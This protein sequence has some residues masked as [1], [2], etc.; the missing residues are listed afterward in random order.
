MDFSL[1]KP[2]EVGESHDKVQVSRRFSP[3]DS[4]AGRLPRFFS[5]AKS[6]ECLVLLEVQGH[7][8]NTGPKPVGT[9][10]SQAGEQ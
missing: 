3:N 9:A 1:T 10:S 2:T 4:S 8:K 6:Y 5:S 7:Y